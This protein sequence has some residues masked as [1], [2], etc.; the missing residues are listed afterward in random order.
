MVR[1]IITSPPLPPPPPHYPASELARMCAGSKKNGV[2]VP[3]RAGVESVRLFFVQKWKF[4]NRFPPLW[5][6]TGNNPSNG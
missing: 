6:G 3:P 4:T 1:C 2:A 5:E